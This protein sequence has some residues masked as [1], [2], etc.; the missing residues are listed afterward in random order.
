MST[1]RYAEAHKNMNGPGDA[2]PTALQIVQDEDMVGKLGGKVMLITGCTSGIGVETARALHATGADIYITA[3]DVP[4]AEQVVKDILASSKGTGKLEV[5]EIELDSLESVRSGAKDFLSRSSSKLNVLVNNAGVMACPE[6]TTKDGFETQFGVN[7]VAHFLLFELLKPALLASSTPEF[8]S[9]V[10]SLSSSGHHGSPVQLDD[11][12]FKKS[13]YEPWKSYGQAKTAN[14]YLATEIERRYGARGLHATAVMPGG[15]WTPLQRHISNEQ[16]K[17]WKG[18]EIEKFFKSTEQGA[19]T[20]VW[21]AIGQHWEG[22]GGKYLEDCDVARPNFEGGLLN[23]GYASYAY[24]EEAAK[25]LW[26]ISLK[27]VG[28]SDDKEV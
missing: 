27:L 10:V 11:L 15:I 28:L 5:I 25:K 1:S 3:R 21:A 20:T 2:R 16:M 4:K 18:P 26:Q 24:D 7:H 9:R 22:A 19:A 8:N 13:G 17:A 6:G 12:D 14:I 23:G